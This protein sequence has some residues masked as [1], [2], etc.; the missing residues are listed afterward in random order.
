[1]PAT[2]RMDGRTCEEASDPRSSGGTSSG[3]LEA[4]VFAGVLGM[5][6]GEW[7]LLRFVGGMVG[8]VVS[9]SSGT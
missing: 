3:A 4:G 6:S 2:K 8:V 7:M 9:K 5:L 1:M